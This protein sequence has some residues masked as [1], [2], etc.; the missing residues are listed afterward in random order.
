MRILRKIALAAACL[1]A[2]PCTWSHAAAETNAVLTPR[3]MNKAAVQKEF[4]TNTV[5]YG[6]NTDM[7]V[8]L[9]LL[10]NRK[11]KWVRI[12]AE[13]T[14]L[15]P[16]SQSEFFL[17]TENSGHDYEAIAIS[18]A[19]PSDV[20][21]A[22]EFIGMKAGR[23]VNME[24]YCFWPKGERVIATVTWNAG[25]EM[26]ARAESL[27]TNRK[28]GG[29]LPQDGFVFVGSVMRDPLDGSAGP[30]VY[31]ADAFGPNCIASYFIMNRAQLI[32]YLF[33][34]RNFFRCYCKFWGETSCCI[35]H[36]LVFDFHFFRLVYL[37]G[38]NCYCC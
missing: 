29:P 10:A 20:H 4:E 15:L 35:T 32:S 8:R 21:F 17:I 28:M 19:K 2:V 24:K 9:G 23:P 12:M 38:F 37:I 26:R 30:K 14:A 5:A 7:L 33:M 22:L 25:K 31:A 16:T 1:I 18:F 3:E 34:V 27:V 6:T 11:E 36:T 13:A